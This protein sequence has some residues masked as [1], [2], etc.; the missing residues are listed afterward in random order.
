MTTQQ[1]SKIRLQTAFMLAKDL[2][3]FHKGDLA[4]FDRMVDSH[5]KGIIKPDEA[6][7]MICLLCQKAKEHYPVTARMLERWVNR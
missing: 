6:Q 2:R 4:R 3:A 1:S 5:G 7:R